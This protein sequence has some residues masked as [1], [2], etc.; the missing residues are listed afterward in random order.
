MTSDKLPDSTEADRGLLQR[1]KGFLYQRGY[2]PHRALEIGVERGVVVVQGQVPT[3]YLRQIAVECIKRV[4]GVIQVVDLIKVVDGRVQPQTTD[5]PV[6]EQESPT[7][8]TRHNAVVPDMAGT[9]KDA[10]RPYFR[11]LHLLSSAKC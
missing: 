7:V 6:D 8:S 9:A 4:A 2:A 10:S 5:S 3:F 1:V 11:R